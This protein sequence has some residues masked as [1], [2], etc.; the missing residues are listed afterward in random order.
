VQS[1]QPD[2]MDLLTRRS[3]SRIHR[4]ARVVPPPR[5]SPTET[6]IMSPSTSAAAHP[7]DATET[8]VG[9][10]PQPAADT[11]PAPRPQRPPGRS[12]R[13]QTSPGD[14][15]ANLAVRI[16]GP[17]DDRLAQVVLSLRD[18]RPRTSKAELVEMLLWQLP[19]TADDQLRAQLRSF[20]QATKPDNL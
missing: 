9:G 18:V 19:P 11:Q 8:P 13:P 3:E 16:R 17:I 1:Q 10:S 6:A 14:P 15:T 5:R 20:R 12:Q 2:G 7:A 4:A